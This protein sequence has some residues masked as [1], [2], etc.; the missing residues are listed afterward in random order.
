MENLTRGIRNNNPANIRRGC[1]WKGLATPVGDMVI[2]CNR[3]I[4]YDKE[5]CQFTSDVFG[6][7]ALIIILRTYVK[8]H[9]LCSIE[10]IVNRFA[11]V[12]DGNST[13][14]Y[15][16][17]V[18]R[19]FNSYLYKGYNCKDDLCLYFDKYHLSFHN[20]YYYDALYALCRAI[21]LIESNYSLRANV[22]NHAISIL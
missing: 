1:N 19:E 11:P 8:K 13:L 3:T 18:T 16:T 20:G 6:V 15:I 12:S 21:C 17:F 5:F 4:K 10:Q 9:G 22:F 2:L 14:K 7:R